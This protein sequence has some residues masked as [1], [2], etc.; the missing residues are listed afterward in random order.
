MLAALDCEAEFL[1]DEMSQRW[2]TRT[3]DFVFVGENLRIAR[4]RTG[5]REQE[6]LEVVVHRVSDENTVLQQVRY[7]FLDIL[8]G[9]CFVRDS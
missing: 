3:R 2:T 1:F 9:S 8:K 7:F 4:L 5:M 6:S